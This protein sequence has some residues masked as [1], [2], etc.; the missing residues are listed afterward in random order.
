MLFRLPP[1]LGAIVLCTVAALP[2]GAQ[3]ARRITGEATYLPRIALAPDAVLIVEARGF[4]DSGLALART[5]TGGAQVPLAF[6][7][8]IP[9][10]VEATLRVG[11]ASG[12][13]VA[14]IGAP[15]TVEPGSGDVD[16]GDV[17]LRPFTP[18]GFT[19]A[20]RCGDRLIRVGLSGEDAVMDTGEARIR[21]APSAAASGARFEAPDDPGTWVWNRGAEATVSIAGT[22]LPDCAMTL[23]TDGEGYT[24]RGNEP[25]WRADIQHGRM[26]ILRPD[27]EDLDLPVMSAGLTPG[28]DIVI[29]A[30]DRDRAIRAV[31]LRKD[32]LCRDTMSGM[33]YPETTE[34]AMGDSVMTGCGGDARNLLTGREWLVEDIGGVP[35]IE[36]ARP[37]LLFDAG[38]RVAGSGGCNRWF[39][40]Y[41]LTGEGL[42]FGPAGTTM[43]ACPD[44][45]MEQE[46]RFLDALGRTF[47][48]DFDEAGALVLHGP[49]GPVLRARMD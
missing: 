29:E 32:M 9:E 48:H 19:S 46:R 49:E 33:P 14:W 47:R 40:G 15:L 3:E 25:F 44:P 5:S 4:G 20:F 8:E 22:R 31:L 21:L 24:A 23:P 30:R 45:L 26:E 41:E 7:L 37:T 18:M 12:G 36:G 2:L 13:Q 43:M 11:I 1:T 6:S 16:L 39:S 27:A 10:G 38:G 28:G 17:I 34:L 42:S 35:A